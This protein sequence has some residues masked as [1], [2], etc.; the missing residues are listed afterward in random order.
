MAIDSQPATGAMTITQFPALNA[1]TA[2]YEGYYVKG[3]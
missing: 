3:V 2:I 1:T